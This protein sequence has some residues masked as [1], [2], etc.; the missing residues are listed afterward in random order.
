[1]FRIILGVMVTLLFNA[2]SS[3]QYFTPKSLA[4]SSSALYSGGEI[5][6]FN[7]DSATL[8]SGIVLTKTKQLNL[9]LKHGYG[10]INGSGDG[11]IIANRGGK[12]KILRGGKVQTINFPKELLAGRVIGNELIYILKDNSFGIYDLSKDTIT[13]NE[14]GERVYSIDA[15]VTNPLK[16]DKLVVIPLLNGKIA[17]LNLNNKKIIKEIFVSTKSILNNIIFLK[18]FHKDILVISTPHKLMTAS[19]RGRREIEEEIS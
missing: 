2:C 17:V 13:F 1:M 10:F 15:R 4:S 19:N 9:N 3:K 14:K 16:V 5:V 11:V 6:Y 18:Q 8:D 7:R 12:C